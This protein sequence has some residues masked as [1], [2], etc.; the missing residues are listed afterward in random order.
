MKGGLVIVACLGKEVFL[1][2]CVLGK[3]VMKC[4]AFYV[5]IVGNYV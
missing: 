2:L 4:S 1:I 3:G 5:V